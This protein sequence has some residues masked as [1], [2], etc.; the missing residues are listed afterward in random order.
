MSDAPSIAPWIAAQTRQL[1]A[2][3]GHAWLL[4]G[5]SG[6]GQYDLAMALV[7]AWLCEHPTGQGACGVCTSCHAIAVR[8]H[9]DLAV[10]MPETVMIE[11]G[12]PL[13]EKAQGEID[14]KKRKPSKEIRV[15]AMR[16]TVEFAQRTSA[17]G[18]GKAV[19]VYPAE[20]MNPVT[21]NA[22][23]KTLEEPPGDVKFVLASE[24][25]HQLLPTI[26]S[27]CL[28]HAMVWPGTP[29]ALAWLAAQGVEGEQA[30][31]WLRAAGG[32]PDDALRL[33]RSGRAAG[34]WAQLPRDLARGE[35]MALADY[36]PPQAIDALQKLCHDLLA[37]LS[38]A[39]P[40]FFDSADLPPAPVASMAALGAWSKSLS[41]AARTAEHP[42]NPGLMLETLSMQAHEILRLP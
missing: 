39:A 30:H 13:S 25:A 7:S 28:G 4:Q 38:G 16:D 22:L 2:Q 12:W 31:V 37:R 42:F 17:R 3:R 27:R 18:R 41:Q 10:L 6:L 11:R 32:R 21:A 5:P 34:A 26:R 8:T 24:A 35:A 1:L 33:A 20:R 23:L 14:D 15:E 29:P 40:R 19:L 9:A 36:T